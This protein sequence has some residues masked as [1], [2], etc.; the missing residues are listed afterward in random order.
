MYGSHIGHLFKDGDGADGLDCPTF[1]LMF[2]QAVEF[3]FNCP[4]PITPDQKSGA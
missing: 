3:A 1:W 4:W 2:L